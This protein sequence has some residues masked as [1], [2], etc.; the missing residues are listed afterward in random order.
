MAKRATRPP[1]E[2]PMKLI[3][4]ISCP[5]FASSSNFCS[6][7]L[8][9]RSPPVSTPSYVKLPAL[10]FATRMARDSSGNFLRRLVLTYLRCSGLPHSLSVSVYCANVF[11]KNAG[12]AAECGV[13][14]NENC[15][16]VCFICRV[17]G[18]WRRHGCDVC[19]TVPGAK[20]RRSEDKVCAP[21]R[22]RPQRGFIGRTT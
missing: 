11:P 13:P 7:S 20:Q 4:L 15:E 21:S 22:S 3:F 14:V 5:S 1:R 8:A 10:R 12:C 18:C 16:V 6:T 17:S 19:R 2:Y 9:T